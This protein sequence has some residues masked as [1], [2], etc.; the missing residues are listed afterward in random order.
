MKTKQSFR[1]LVTAFMLMALPTSMLAQEYITEIMSLGAKKG[2]GTEL[3]KKYRNREFWCRG[4]YVDTA[5]KNADR[6]KAYIQQQLEE[7]K[8]GEQMSMFGK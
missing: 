4:Y 7:D 1:L 6:I 2:G 8:M 5:G 3:K